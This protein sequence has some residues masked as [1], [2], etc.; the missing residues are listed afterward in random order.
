MLNAVVIDRRTGDGKFGDVIDVA[1]WLASGDW[2]SAPNA[3]AVMARRSDLYREAT[4]AMQKNAAT[5]SRPIKKRKAV[6][7][8]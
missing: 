7:A 6:Q 4:E 5:K 2:G 8:A 1:E 3:L